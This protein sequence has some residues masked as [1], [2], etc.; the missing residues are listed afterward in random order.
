MDDFSACVVDLEQII[1]QLDYNVVIPANVCDVINSHCVLS[2][3]FGKLMF[4]IFE[5]KEVKM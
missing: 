1:W 5:K 3:V 2:A 4:I